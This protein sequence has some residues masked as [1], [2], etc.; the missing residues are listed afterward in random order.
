MAAPGFYDERARAAEAA[1]EHKKLMWEVGELMGQGEAL[2]E[3]LERARE[4]SAGA[5]PG[6]GR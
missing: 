3:E 4:E 5:A 1:E 2:Q 6:P